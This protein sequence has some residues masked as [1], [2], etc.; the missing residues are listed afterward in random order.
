MELRIIKENLNNYYS[1]PFP[2]ISDSTEKYE[3]CNWC[4]K[5]NPF[6]EIRKMYDEPLYVRLF[7]DHWDGMTSSSRN[8]KLF[9][10]TNNM[11]LDFYDPWYAKIS[12]VLQKPYA[13]HHQ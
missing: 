4:F 11:I 8:A 5:S 7:E 6:A 10:Y 3:A 1:E 9:E 2:E 13:H 12:I